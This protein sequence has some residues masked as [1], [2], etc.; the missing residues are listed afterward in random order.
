MQALRPLAEKFTKLMS[1]RDSEIESE[2]RVTD[3][4]LIDRM[5]IVR[6]DVQ[7]PKCF[8]SKLAFVLHH[9]L[10]EKVRAYFID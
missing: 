5:D 4:E 10:T 2:S 7:L 9:V 8:Q 3:E 1:K 6:E